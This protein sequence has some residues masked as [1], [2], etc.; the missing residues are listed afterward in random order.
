[1]ITEWKQSEDLNP[2]TISQNDVRVARELLELHARELRYLLN[3]A[4][5]WIFIDSDV[6]SRLGN[7][8]NRWER[9]VFFFHNRKLNLELS[10]LMERLDKLM[11]KIAQDTV[12]EWIG[13]RFRTGYK[14]FRIVSEEEY[15]RRQSEAREANRIA[16]QAWTLLDALATKIKDGIPEAMD[17]AVD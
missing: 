7:L 5:L 15:L 1:L 13:G 3:D 11:M 17:K 14:P 2:K 9:G 8:C 4:D 6:Y 12:P 10:A 16:S